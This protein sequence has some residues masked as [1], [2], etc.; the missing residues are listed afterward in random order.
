[1]EL[2]NHLM[3]WLAVTSIVPLAIFMA[4]MTYYQERFFVS[5]VDQE[6]T[7]ELVRLT[8]KLD[9]HRSSQ[10]HFVSALAKTH[11]LEQFGQAYLQ[12]QHSQISRAQYHKAQQQLQEQLNDLQQLLSKD[13]QVR[14]LNEAGQALLISS[15]SASPQTAASTADWLSNASLNTLLATLPNDQ[16]SFINTSKWRPIGQSSL[17]ADLVIPVEI[18]ADTRLYLLLQ[19]NGSGYDALLNLSS[20]LRDIQLTL[21]LSQESSSSSQV[22]YDD[23]QLI[24]FTTD[25]R[26]RAAQDWSDLSKKQSIHN[27]VYEDVANDTRIYVVDYQPYP[28]NIEQ[29]QLLARLNRSSQIRQFDNIRLTTIA[30]ALFSLLLIGTIASEATRRLVSPIMRLSTNMHAF[31]ND[32]P[33]KPDAPTL[34]A[35]VKKLQ[36]TF[37]LMMKRVEVSREDRLDSERRLLETQKLASIGEMAAGIGHELNNPLNNIISLAKLIRSSNSDNTELLE[38]IHSLRE[39]AFRAS[40]IVAGILNF[41]REVKPEIRQFDAIDWM[42]TCES[43]ITDLAAEGDIVINNAF[44]RAMRINGDPNQLEQVVINLLNNAIQASP[45]NS[46]IDVAIYQDAE[47]SNILIQDQG[48]GFSDDIAKRIFEPFFTTK[49]VGEGSGL[50]LAIS[51]GIVE[52]HGGKLELANTTEGGCLARVTL[53]ARGIMPS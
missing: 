52:S 4:A 12:R 14:V 37:Q 42:L 27:K 30:L 32:L 38:D 13:V 50:G 25:Q 24:G 18:I 9:D 40:R 7:Q 35:E 44:P 47:T 39:E 31:A 34:S 10:Q 6:V 48:P 17:L 20:R 23:E 36:S 5:S 33:I 26:G 45:P 2:R 49:D 43:R 1:M 22:L 53:P 16:V 3:L 28:N 41:A 29:W 11:A 19:Q 51:M 15:N 8:A 46:Q 21:L